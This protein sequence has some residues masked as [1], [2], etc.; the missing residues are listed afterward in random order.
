MLLFLLRH[1]HTSKLDRKLAPRK[2]VDFPSIRHEIRLG[3][4]TTMVGLKH[5]FM[6]LLTETIMK[7]SS[8]SDENTTAN[9]ILKE[10]LKYIE[11]RKKTTKFIIYK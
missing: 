9:N 6:K 11:V 5:I 4:I 10:G 8:Q 1:I 2:L 7:T 3:E